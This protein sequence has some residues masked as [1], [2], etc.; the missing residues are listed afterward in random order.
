MVFGRVDASITMLINFKQAHFFDFFTAT[1]K[2]KNVQGD[3][4]SLNLFNFGCKK[5]SS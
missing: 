3:D 2:N 4:A 5:S 1:F